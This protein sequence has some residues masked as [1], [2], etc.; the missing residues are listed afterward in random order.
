METLAQRHCTGH[1][2][3]GLPC[4]RR[5]IPGGDVCTC[6]GGAAPQTREAANLRLLAGRDLAIDALIRAL[7]SHGQPCEVCGRSDGDRD[8][9]V[10]RAAQI[11]L[12]RTGHHPTISIQQVPSDA[13]EWSRYLTDDECAL[14]DQVIERAKTRMSSGLPDTPLL[15]A[16]AI[17]ADSF[18]VPDDDPEPAP[19]DDT[20]QDA[21]PVLL[22]AQGVSTIDKPK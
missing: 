12:D 11:V 21:A 13:A 22:N 9:A 6:H 7:D 8:P 14:M 18:E 20:A 16:H 10:I 3:Q 19:Q 4:G 5:P 2:R 15:D 17:D 1:N